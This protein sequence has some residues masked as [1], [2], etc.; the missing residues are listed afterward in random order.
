[1]LVVGS[2]SRRKFDIIKE[3]LKRRLEEALSNLGKNTNHEKLMELL[4]IASSHTGEQS[5]EDIWFECTGKLDDQNEPLNI[6]VNK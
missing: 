5:N 6:L 3:E 1:M 2:S 4:D